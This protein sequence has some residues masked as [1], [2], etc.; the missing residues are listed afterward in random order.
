M[1]IRIE[2]QKFVAERVL[3]RVEP[4][5][6]DPCKRT[7]LVSNEIWDLLNGPWEAEQG[8]RCA[9]LSS[10]LQQIATGA[11]LVVE[12]DPRKARKANMG[13][14]APVE[15]GVWDIR[16]RGKPGIRV[17]CFFLEMDVLVAFFCSPRSVPI[18]WLDRLPLGVGNSVEWRRAI[19]ESKR[20]W[21]KLFP[22]HN[23]LVGDDLNAY[24]SNAVHE[25][26]GG[27]A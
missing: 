22:A 26:D 6:G 11:T 2:W 24:L 10:T 8:I 19:A 9:L 27:G 4:F 15:A 17:F 1:S 3:H 16:C 20:E 5:P 12:M 13:R 14:L 7:V 18:S 21:A 23:P 25:R